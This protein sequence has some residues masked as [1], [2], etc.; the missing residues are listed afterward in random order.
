MQRLYAVLKCILA[1]FCLLFSVIIVFTIGKTAFFTDYFEKMDSLA[2]KIGGAFVLLT[3]LWLAFILCR[4]GYRLFMRVKASGNLQRKTSV[5]LWEGII[6]TIVCSS[7]GA[8][9]M[10]SFLFRL[11]TDPA[12]FYRTGEHMLTSSAVVDFWIAMTLSSISGFL[13][14]RAGYRMLN[15]VKKIVDAEGTK[16]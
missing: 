8:V 9:L 7:L 10:L 6:R 4:F 14:L 2:K 16:I 11:G 1:F 5:S 13:L 12:V 15:Q 3:F